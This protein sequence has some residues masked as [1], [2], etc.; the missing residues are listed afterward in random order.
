MTT[1]DA[2]YCW[3][4]NKDGQLGIGYTST[5][6]FKVPT[7]VTGGHSF[8]VVT[9]GFLHTCGST[10]SDEGYCWGRNTTGQ[11]GIG[12]TGGVHSAPTSVTGGHSFRSISGGWYHSCGVTTADDAYC[13]GLNNW[14]QLGIGSWGGTYDEPNP[15]TSGLAFQLVTAGRYHSCGVTTGND[16]Y[17]WG[18]NKYGQLGDESGVNKESPSYAMYLGAPSP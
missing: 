7:P 15:V 14:G 9:G 16:A 2:A 17:C 13:W 4:S 3:G 10:T 11:L 18:L 1:A 12:S 8:R 5:D 6:P